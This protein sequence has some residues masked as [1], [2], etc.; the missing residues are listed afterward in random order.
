MKNIPYRLIGLIGAER[1]AKDNIFF[2][3]LYGTGTLISPNL[4]LTTAHNIYS[5][6]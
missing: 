5:G 1:K 2:S 6:Q 4:V 3:K